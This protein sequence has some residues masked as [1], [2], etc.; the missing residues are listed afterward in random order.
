MNTNHTFQSAQPADWSTFYNDLQEKGKL[1]NYANEIF[2]SQTVFRNMYLDL[3]VVKD[4][5]AAS[6]ITPIVTT[7]YTDVLHIP[8]NTNWILKNS[9]LVVFARRIETGNNTNVM[10]D[11]R[12]TE[13]ARLV[14]FS[15]DIAGTIGI[16]AVTKDP[17]PFDFSISSTNSFSGIIINSEQGRPERKALTAAQGIAF[18]VPNDLPLYLGNTFINGSLLYDQA[19]EL[20][21]LL[22]T[23]V[24]NW[25]AQ[26]PNFAELFYKSANLL[27]LLSAQINAKAGGA[28]FVPYLTSSIYKSLASA[29]ANEAAKYENDYMQLSTQKVLTEQGIALAKTMIANSK[30]EIDY[31]AALQKQTDENYNNAVN[32]E[33][34][35]HANFN[36]QQIAVAM[37]AA[38]FEQVGLPDYER[39]QIIKAI[40]QLATAVVTF[41]AAIAAIAMG[42]GEAAPAAASSAINGAKAVANA[43]E[44][45]A[46]VAK[47]A[48]GLSDSMENL[49]KLVEV[50]KKVYE[51]AKAVQEIASNIQD[52]KGQMEAIQ[53]MDSLTNGTDLSATEGWIL[54]KLQTEAVL[55]EP[56]EKGIHFAG[57]YLMALQKLIIYGQSMSAAQLAVITSGQQS[58]AI[59]FRLHYAEEKQKQLQQYVDSLKVGE[60]PILNMMQ[61][62]YQRYTDSKSALFS[63]LKSY[64]ASYYY[65]ALRSSS[66]QPRII[67]SVNDMNAGIQDITKLAMDQADAMNQF[68]PA[69]QKMGNTTVTIK[70]PAILKALIENGETTWTLPLTDPEFEGLTR[71]RISTIR[72]WLEGVKTA[73]ENSVFI[74]ITNSGSYHDRFQGTN[75]QFVSK[76][77]RRT[78]KYSVHTSNDSPGTPDWRFHNGDLGYVQIDGKVD[79]EVS[80]AYFVPTPFSDWTISLKENNTGID[81]S[82]LT[83]I[84]MYFEGSVIGSS[85]AKKKMMTLSEAEA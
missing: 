3:G 69:P 64:Q 46:E 17:Q 75:Y 68:D 67:D 51:L 44:T 31:V 4:K 9:A 74:S 29:F 7:L 25:A 5:I 6:G 18:H 59:A 48:K 22:F 1:P 27:T 2:G 66:I 81:Y 16:K 83:S 40:F 47:T 79:S 14:I 28:V 61:T 36:R 85:A 23:W 70:D 10:L 11:F 53:K 78:F 43:A 15:N 45:G 20:A 58:A 24:K 50:L 13:L 62:F 80:F 56:V 63:A 12:E 30:S 52:A 77:L 39:E 60:E 49:K 84:T 8:D 72:I 42:Q 55:K 71:V 21:L 34:I 26:S 82:G 76:P 38:D 33:K 37:I 73:N 54:F 19:P 57:E 65:W 41:G 32:A 35:A